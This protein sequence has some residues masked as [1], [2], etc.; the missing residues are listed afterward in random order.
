MA[1]PLSAE[2]W[3]RLEP[4]V[5]AVADLPR[6]RQP[7]FL[8]QACGSDADLRAELEQLL[9]HF[10]RADTLLDRPA[11]QR[12]GSLLG[13]MP[14]APPE[15][16]NDN[17]RIERRLGQGGMATVYLAHDLRH[18]RKVAI[19]VLHP[20]LS[21]AFRPEQFLAEIRTMAR[22][23]HP[24][25]LQVHDSGEVDGLLFY[26]MPYVE[27]E[28]LRQRIE[29]NVQLDPGEAARITSE[30]A[31][32]LDYAHRHGVIHRDIKP[33]NIL[34]GEGGVQVADFGIALAISTASAGDQNQPGWIAGTPRYMSPEQMAGAG[35]LDG[36]SDVYALGAVAYEMLTGQPP[37]AGPT[38]SAILAGSVI[39]PPPPSLRIL[40]DVIPP[41]VDAVVARALAPRPED[42]YATG[43]AFAGALQ[44]SLA[45]PRSWRKAALAA[46]VIIT[47]TAAVAATRPVTHPVPRVHGPGTRNLAAYDFYQRGRDQLFAR[48]DSGVRVALEYFRQAVAADSTFAAAYAELAHMNA[49]L[50]LHGGGRVAAGDAEAAALKAVSL[51]DSLSDAH[52]EL[53]FE[54]MFAWY[55][56]AAAGRELQRAVALDPASSRAH[57]YLGYYY[58]ATGRPADA[59]SEARRAIELDPQSVEDRAELAGAL[60]CS[61]HFD[62]ALALVDTLRQVTPPLARLSGLAAHIYM[63]KGMWPEAI[64][65]LGGKDST[66]PDGVLGDALAHAGYR[67]EARRMLDELI[68]SERREG[69]KAFE[70]ALIYEGLGDYD[71]AF[72]WVDKSIDEHTFSLELMGEPVYDRLRAD[73]RYDRIRQ[74]L[75]LINV[76]R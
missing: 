17:Y 21:A 12:F 52:A 33:E 74:R 55:D 40:R 27:G 35:T 66:G 25:I 67:A 7:A 38:V 22:L 43:G 5:D 1:S 15:I 18:D 45:R 13:L 29:R 46:A 2:R 26:V 57:D 70:I 63:S 49:L 8:D 64:A 65:E 44:Q 31:S 41:S 37:F 47:V 42:R 54:R 34:L 71:N 16:L 72:V 11:A 10:E 61:R 48:S 75:R 58:C 68:G 69:G 59:L 9:R 51:D 24:H 76:A 20:E 30:V 53:G 56:L 3:K 73:P 39:R 32:A 62:E 6:N 14:V 23:Q 28:T 60:Y 19:K 36:R 50:V 4:L